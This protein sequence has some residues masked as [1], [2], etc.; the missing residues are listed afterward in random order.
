MKKKDT[1]VR[2]CRCSL[3]REAFSFDGFS[4]AKEGGA[5]GTREFYNPSVATEDQQHRRI[6]TERVRLDCVSGSLFCRFMKFNT[7]FL[8]I[9][10]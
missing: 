5:N 1:D 7:I 10:V 9:L 6:E 2:I 3:N 4:I 8:H